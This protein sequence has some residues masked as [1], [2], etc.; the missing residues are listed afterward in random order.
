MLTSLQN[1]LVKQ[2][3]KL[4]AAKG[5]REQD[6][7][8]LEGTHLLAE[9]RATD[10]HP[11]AVC[12]TPEWGERHPELWDWAVRTAGRAEQ[13]SDRVLAAMTT[14]VH[15]DG[16]VAVAPRAPETPA[17]IR[18]LGLVLETLQDPGNLGT[19]IRTAAA[20]GV[21]GLW[22]SADSVDRDHPKVLRASAGAW[23]RLPIAVHPDLKASLT[24]CRERGIQIVATLPDAPLSYWD[25]DWRKPTAIVL[26]N[27]GAGLSE[28]LADLADHRVRVPLLNG[29]ES[30]NVATCA[31]LILYEARR[32]RQVAELD[33]P[34]SKSSDSETS[35]C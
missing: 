18:G 29:V 10:W 14:T 12:C 13:V 1:P 3:K 27:E 25:L 4:H 34:F 31:A 9:C 11:T 20:A 15:P 32:Q 35:G 19:L 21:E 33:Q 16:V 22:L 8:L 28:P 30:L 26:G 5:R 23:F 2:F 7:F 24:D 17:P 6:S